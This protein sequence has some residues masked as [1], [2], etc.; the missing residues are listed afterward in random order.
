MRKLILLAIL[1]LGNSSCSDQRQPITIITPSLPAT[2]TKTASLPD[3]INSDCN[4]SDFATQEE[5]QAVL[6]ADKNRPLA[7]VFCDMIECY[8]FV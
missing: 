5:A 1:V 3:C 4:C 2:T 7:K 6:N 8:F